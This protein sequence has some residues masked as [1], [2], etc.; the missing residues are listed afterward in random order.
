MI[1]EIKTKTGV[2]LFRSASIDPRGGGVIFA[3]RT[4]FKSEARD[5]VTQLASY[6]T[7]IHGNNVL[8]S[9]TPAAAERAIAAPWDNDKKCAIAEIDLYLN[10]A[11]KEVDRM[12]WVKAPKIELEI[13]NDVGKEAQPQQVQQYI[14]HYN[15]ALF[16]DDKSIESFRKLQSIKQRYEN[17]NT[18]KTNTPTKSKTSQN[19]TENDLSEL[20]DTETVATLSTRV[21]HM[22]KNMK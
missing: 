11:N 18:N 7:F 12:T 8:K 21:S 1:M 5:L 14:N 19:S 3:Y 10:D 9:F 6:L 4:I 17:F 22:D 2:T 16:T 15:P 13:N 20:S